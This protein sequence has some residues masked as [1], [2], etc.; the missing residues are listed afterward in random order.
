MRSVMLGSA[1]A[2]SRVTSRAELLLEPSVSS[3]KMLAFGEIDKGVA[4][5]RSE[6]TEHLDEIRALV[7][8]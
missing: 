7:A 4:I 1:A 8:R 6:A 2:G 3:L 5:G